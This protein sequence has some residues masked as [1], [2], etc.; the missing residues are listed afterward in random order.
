MINGINSNYNSLST[1]TFL[2]I[3]Q[4][5]VT[6]ALERLASTI[7][8]NH[9]SDDPS[10]LLMAIQMSNQITGTQ[11]G[12]NNLSMAVD[13]LNTADSY[14]RI[15]SEDLEAMAGLAAQASNSLL[16][17]PQRQ[18]LD[19]SY[20]NLKSEVDRLATTVE[21]NGRTLLDG[22][23]TNVTVQAGASSANTITLNIGDLTTGAAGLNIAG[24]NILTQANATAATN[25]L[26]AAVQ[27]VLGPT[28]AEIG[29]QSASMLKS[30]DAQN[31]YATNLMAARS[32]IMDAD[33]AAETTNLINSQI[34]VKAGV[35]A[36]S[37][38]NKAREY[39]LNLLV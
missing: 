18:L 6:K 29:A 16:T 22:T 8:I 7:R 12:T 5:S 33:I 13:L 34:I 10:G 21:F 1:Q 26:N 24:T 35:K 30:I 31:T 11:A 9:A 38:A 36:L 20:Q 2:S 25:Q 23:L 32:Y 37:L 39:A 17:D 27:N 15:I 4:R 3:A 14:T 19:V 28:V